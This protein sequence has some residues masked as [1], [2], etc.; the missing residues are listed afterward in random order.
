MDRK[1]FLFFLWFW[2]FMKFVIITQ[3]F[4]VVHVVYKFPVHFRLKK[5][6]AVGMSRDGKKIT[7]RH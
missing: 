7:D 6:I 2:R 4:Y 5:C 1:W 3:I